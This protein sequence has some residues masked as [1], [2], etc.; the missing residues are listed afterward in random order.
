MSRTS[1]AITTAISD[2]VSKRKLDAGAVEELEELLIRADFGV[3]VAARIAGAGGEG[4]YDKMI[5]SDEVKA[6]L[7]AEIEKILAP[8]EKPLIID[9]DLKPCVILVAGVGLTPSPAAANSRLTVALALSRP[10]IAP[11]A[12]TASA[13]V[14]STASATVR[15]SSTVTNSRPTACV[16]CRPISD[17][18]PLVW[19]LSKY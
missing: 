7:A 2:L 11:T 6:I 4:R 3:D 1:D 13:K 16:G 15:S 12:A 19:E 17:D 5:S 18:S 10:A 9:R 14:G 8:V